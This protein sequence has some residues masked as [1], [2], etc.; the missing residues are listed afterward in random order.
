MWFSRNFSLIFT[1]FLLTQ[2]KLIHAAPTVIEKI[3][4]AEIFD[5]DDPW[6]LPKTSRPLF[7]KLDITSFAHNGTIDFT[8]K[9]DIL[10]EVNQDTPEIVL[11]S[12]NLQYNTIT[13][14]KDANMIPTTYQLNPSVETLTIKLT[15]GT[16]KSRE[17]YRIVA[18]YTGKLTNNYRGFI[19]TSYFT[20]NG[21]EVFVAATQFE[22]TN[23]RSVFPSYDEPEYKAVF[24]LSLTHDKY[25]QAI[26]NTLGEVVDN[27]DGTVTTTFLQS[28][29]MSSYL[30]A[31]ALTDY[32][33]ISNENSI[34]RTTINRV[35][36]PKHLIN[37]VE[38][39][40]Q[41]SIRTI[42]KLE[43]YLSTNYSLTKLDSV[44]IPNLRAIGMENWGIIT[45]RTSYLI[46][47]INSHPYQ[48][49][50]GLSLISHEQAHMFFGNLVTTHW[51]DTIWLNEGFA[52]FFDY[53]IPDLLYPEMELSTHFFTSTLQIALK[54]DFLKTTRPMTQAVKA[55]PSD[56][57]G[58][59]DSIAYEKSGCVLRMFQEVIGENVF[60]QGLRNYLQDNE[61]ESGT[62]AKFYDAMQK[63]IDSNGLNFE[64]ANIFKTWENQK[65]YPVVH[66]SY[67]P[68]DKLFIL[69]QTHFNEEPIEVSLWTIPFNYIIQ[70]NSKP[71]YFYF[72]KDNS[73]KFN[74][75]NVPKTNQWYI[76][77]PQ[78]IGFYRVN[79]DV[80]NWKNLIQTLNSRKIFTIDSLTR[81][82]LLSDSIS[83]AQNNQLGVSISFDLL[84]YLKREVEYAPWKII[85][86]YL[87]RMH[88]LIY[89]SMPEKE[90][91]FKKFVIELIQNSFERYGF[92][93]FPNDS[94]MDKFIRELSIDLACSMGLESCLSESYKHLIDIL[95]NKAD[96]SK[97]VEK[98]IYF[99]GLRGLNKENDW[100]AVL[101]SLS[102]ENDPVQRLMIV[103]SLSFT[104][105]SFL[106]ELV[107]STIANF[108]F[109]AQEPMLFV[110]SI[111]SNSPIGIE[112]M[113]NYIENHSLNTNLFN[114]ESILQTLSSQIVS[115]K[116][117]QQFNKIINS[118]GHS[119][120]Q[121]SI[122]KLN[123][124]I[125]KNEEEL[126]NMYLTNFLDSV[127]LYMNNSSPSEANEIYSEFRLPQT[128]WPSSY[129][130]H[131][132]IR[133][134][135]KKDFTGFVKINTTVTANTEKII[136]HYRELNIENV[137]VFNNNNQR[138]NYYNLNLNSTLEF[139][140]IDFGVELN[141]GDY[142][143][144]I[145]YSGKLRGPSSGVYVDTYNID[146]ET[147]SLV[148]T[149]FESD[150]SRQCF[151]SY[152]E[153]LFKATF[154]LKITHDSSLQAFA[155]TD[156]TVVLN[157]D[158]STTTS[159]LETPIMSSYLL[160]FVISDFAIKQSNPGPKE[161]LHRIHA[162]PNGINQTQFGLDSS[163]KI[164][165]RLEEYV[166]IEYE[167]SKMDSVAVPSK[168]GA[169]ENWGLITYAE[170]LL[171]YYGDNPS[172]IP[173]RDLVRGVSVIAHELAHQFFGNYAT[174]KWW[175]TTWLNEGFAAQFQYYLVEL[176]YPEWEF[177]FFNLQKMQAVFIGDSREQTRPM[178]FEV[179]NRN[180]IS[181]SFDEIGYDKSGCVLH[182]FQNAM[183][184]ELF[185]QGLSIY[186]KNNAYKATEPKDFIRDVSAALALNSFKLFDFAK[187]F[188][189]WELQKGYPVVNVEYKKD[190]KEFWLT[191]S[192]FFSEAGKSSKTLWEIPINFATK[193]KPNVN[194]TLATHV[195]PQQS[196]PFPIATELGNNDWYIF[197]IRQTGYYR[198]NYDV[199]NWNNLIEALKHGE[200]D[201]IHYLNRAQ[202]V[203]DAINLVKA[204]QLQ[205]NIMLKLF[206][207]L[208]VE[209]NYL[210][211]AAFEKYLN[212]NEKFWMKRSDFESMQKFILLLVEN[213]YNKLTIEQSANDSL[214]DKFAREFAI[215]WNCRMQNATCLNDAFNIVKKVVETNYEAPIGLRSVIYCGGFMRQNST[216]EW[217]K[218]WDRLKTTKDDVERR[219]IIDGLACSNDDVI[220]EYLQSS[221]GG[222]SEIPY[223]SR[224]ERLRVF[225]SVISS[226]R[227][228]FDWSLKFI[229]EYSGDITRMYNQKLDTLLNTL[230]KV[231]VNDA[232]VK[233][234]TQLLDKLKS[235][236]ET[237]TYDNILK[238][239]KD[240]VERSNNAHSNETLEFMDNYVKNFNED[241]EHGPNSASTMTLSLSLVII[242]VIIKFFVN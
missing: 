225:N 62:P 144:E 115:T 180:D 139:I 77:N 163:I 35:F 40:L 39:A 47:D 125:R 100:F 129:D 66:V 92:R 233:S 189:T 212:E 142:R 95:E 111:I 86:P 120:S 58:V 51:W 131:L 130:L 71:S 156:E 46:F 147:R 44:A 38:M 49:A 165:K 192:Q 113:L 226:N 2:Q 48:L 56:I 60:R 134:I 102:T 119:L 72:L 43:E 97:S 239:A 200:I 198:V 219:A 217:V 177:K 105:D 126:N 164:L 18:D 135:D 202:L 45:Y 205:L 87:K 158:G 183:G 149:Q 23:A 25:Y 220:W 6:R 148:T 188:R 8:G 26:S 10:I 153:P 201:K 64:F 103:E 114:L 104:S 16:L 157:G 137:K 141:Q 237:G 216:N 34:F 204:G 7:Y 121:S 1:I 65:G 41:A 128:S 70:E 81:A 161:T 178:T 155:N 197:N 110:N 208:R 211:F 143:I 76:F 146:S 93:E 213:Q 227:N 15:T 91:I 22:S 221:L 206:T 101:Q 224:T 223:T 207:Y 108:G 222:T 241:K 74:L 179:N 98:S 174:T 203:D 99:N 170:S 37:K 30:L 90:D 117:S 123:Q 182:M 196:E 36:A 107:L 53:L 83:L 229:D 73:E 54:D 31:F 82:Q 162:R 55:I 109:R 61:Y 160:A 14:Y 138:V 89:Q 195:I 214:F 171:I 159:F 116:F 4:S 238:I 112:F 236:L 50:Q 187:A 167:L 186:L 199:D 11:N 191:Q 242:A 235:K 17:R 136:L 172:N 210:P 12:R 42:S 166:D 67:S 122:E 181:R 176:T 232:Q 69:R 59:F 215:K 231:A 152:D 127:E 218:M 118:P 240:N 184:E 85:L 28:P 209:T 21:T 175:S 194:S 154:L 234:L 79:Y 68:D 106:L 132:T 27:G 33:S 29:R 185:R 63:A 20:D 32:A 9:C 173:H 169:M 84:T 88:T 78:Q 3:D 133:N 230:V 57:S 75:T 13:V 96:Y 124:N 140:E 80:E 52:T 193:Q 150:W 5:D 94:T 228:G 151:P 24:N 145:Y 168:G 190:R 19:L